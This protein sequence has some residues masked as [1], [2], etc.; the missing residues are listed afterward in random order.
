[1]CG[2][3][4]ACRIRPRGLH[5]GH[6]SAVGRAGASSIS[7]RAR[8]EVGWGAVFNNENG[9]DTEPTQNVEGLIGFQ[10]SYLTYDRPGPPRV[11]TTFR[12]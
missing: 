6:S 10:G 9:V 5:Y 1:M 2:T 7:N 8:F 11:S 4:V 3:D 12:A